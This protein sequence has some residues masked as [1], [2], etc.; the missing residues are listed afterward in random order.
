ML[1]LPADIRKAEEMTEPSTL[2][3]VQFGGENALLVRVRRSQ[4]S[5]AATSAA[6]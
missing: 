2:P 5:A 6:A 4:P 1:T 3:L